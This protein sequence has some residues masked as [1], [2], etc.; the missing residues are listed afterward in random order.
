MGV[1]KEEKYVMGVHNEV[2]YVRGVV[3]AESVVR[4]LMVMCMDSVTGVFRSVAET[5]CRRSL[6]TRVM[7][8]GS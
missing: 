8:L 7:E 1:H 2:K 5:L 4:I 3:S 6:K